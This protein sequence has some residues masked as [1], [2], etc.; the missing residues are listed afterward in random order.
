MTAMLVYVTCENEGEAV[1]IA[2]AAV[3]ERLAAC[4]NILG[5]VRSLYWWQGKLEE[6]GEVALILKTRGELA[7]KLAERVKELH[8]Y[9]V[10]DISALPIVDGNPDY[11][12]WIAA[13]TS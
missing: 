1:K 11:L 7:A 8:S 12:A 2:R 6:A 10:P 3:G 9:E 4:A 5:A 13:E